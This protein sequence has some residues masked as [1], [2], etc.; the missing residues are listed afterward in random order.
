MRAEN[1]E[2]ID[3]EG[4]LTEVENFWEV[5]DGGSREEWLHSLGRCVSIDQYLNRPK[6]PATCIKPPVTCLS[7]I[8][9]EGLRK[10]HQPSRHLR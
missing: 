2:R 4:G 6:L 10:W 8:K 5:S 3:C 1:R 9:L 7:G